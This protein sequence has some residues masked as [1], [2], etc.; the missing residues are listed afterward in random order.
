MVRVLIGDMFQS[1]AQ[2]WVNTVNTVG[3]MGKGIALE[4]RKR[5]PDMYKDYVERCRFHQVR[6]GQ[7]YLFKRP[8]P[9]W[10]LNFPTKEHWRSPSSLEAI[11]SGLDYL[12][13]HYAEW[14][15][16]SLAVPPL[17]AGQ[18]RLEWRVVG[19]TLYRHLQRLR[20]PVELYAPFGTPHEE[21]EPVYL[22][23]TLVDMEQV[24]PDRVG[25]AWVALVEILDRV[26]QE[27]YH[28]PVGRITFHKLAYFATEAGI[29]TGLEF[30]RSSYGP[31]SRD[32]KTRLAM[33][34]N[35]GLIKEDQLGQMFAVR[36]GRT[37]EDAR[38]FYGRQLAEWEAAIGEVADLFLRIRS[39][40][41]AEFAATV[42]FVTKQLS[43]QLDRLPSE[44]EVLDYVLRWKPNWNREEV[45]VTIRRLAMLE[46]VKLRGSK[47][48]PVDQLA[49]SGAPMRTIRS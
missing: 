39:T 38:R 16:T 30:E 32:L 29:P 23:H 44:N 8:T 43:E 12:E 42:H 7:P 19:P 41:Q 24:S 22:E 36:P 5:F 4:F 20:I 46:T 17:G 37:F 13:E 48:L 2:T 40:R 18:G 1:R 49:T 21:L 35:N 15:I 3:V 28:S 25:A 47:D 6:L 9:P 33:L 45:A 34:I 14:R 11:V 27:R 26:L 10:I 31:F